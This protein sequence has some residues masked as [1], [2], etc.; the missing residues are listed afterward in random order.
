M[1]NFSRLRY[2]VIFITFIANILVFC[3]SAY[4][5]YQSRNQYEDRARTQTQTIARIL[6]QEISV[7]VERIDF[8]LRSV[9]DDIDRQ[10][11]DKGI[12]GPATE[13]LLNRYKQRMPEVEGLRLTNKN[14]DI[15]LGTE[16]DYN[17]KV[18]VA[19]REYFIHHVGNNDDKMHISQPVIGRV[20][21]HYII[22]FSRHYN[23]PD[24]S[25]AGVVYA[26][27]PVD[28]FAALLSRFDV[29]RHGTIVLRDQHLA[30]I[31]RIPDISD[32]PVG[33]V[34]NNTVSG[35]FQQI[36][37]TGAKFSTYYTRLAADGQKRM[38]SFRR[39]DQAE[40]TVIVG[41]SQDDYLADWFKE[42]YETLAWNLALLLATLLSARVLLKTLAAL[43]ESEG[44]F[45]RFFEK[46]SSVML[47]VEPSTG[48]I[49]GA[50][51]V[52]AVFYGY[53]PERLV[54]MTTNEINV[55]PPEDIAQER[56]RALL[57]ERN[58]FSFR[59]RLASNDIRDVEVYA[60][61]IEFDH[62]PLLFSIVHD[63][64][65]RKLAE[66]ARQKSEAHLRSIFDAT[67]DALLISDASGMI[68]M[69]NQRAER[70]LGYLVDDLLGLPV[71][72]LVPKNVRDRHPEL[73][74][75]Y[76]AAPSDLLMGHR[77]EIKVVRK[78]G[79][80]CDV[81]V[82]LGHIEIGQDS[83]VAS[84][85]RDITDRRKAEAE[86][87]IAATAFESQESI[88]VTD[89]QG[90][91]LRVNRAFTENT[92]YTSEEIIGLTPSL[93]KSGRHD[94]VFY[95]EMWQDLT[96]HGVWQGE[97]WDK[98][99]N[100]E[101]YPK[102]LTISAVRDENGVTT[103]YVG[104]H[105]DISERKRAE[106]KII[107][108]AFYDQLT[109][110]PNRTLLL[111]RLS[112][113]MKSRL[114]ICGAL[115]F[116]DLDNFKTLNDTLGHHKGD[117]L[118]CQVAQRL[119]KCVRA[120]DTVA[121]LGGDEF[122]VLLED[123][124]TNEAEASL[125]A[126]VIG[127][128]IK[129]ALNE[130]YLL[131]E[132][133]YHCTPSIGVT[134]FAGDN[135]SVTDL[136]KQADLAMYKSKDAGRNAIHFF[137]PALES[138]VV[139]RASLEA[140]LRDALDHGQFIL[141]YQPQIEGKDHLAGAEALVRWQHPQRGLVPPSDFIPI[142]EETGLIL[143]LGNWVLE[144][145][146]GQL[147][148]WANQPTMADLTIAVNVSAGQFKH[149]NFVEHVLSI[150]KK[151]NANPRRLKLELT[152]SLLVVNLQD[153]IEKMF[154]LKAKGV[155]F[156]LDDFGTGYSSLSYL[157]RL[158][159]DQLKIDQSF[160]R[161]LL[162]DPND[163]AIARTIVA[164]AQSLGLAVIAE[165][166]ETEHQRDFLASSGCH[167]YQGYLFSRPLPL[168]AFEKFSLPPKMK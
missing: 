7:S 129:D 91:I 52:A 87:R 123:L 55:L 9:V 109:G 146:C 46:N 113:A 122:L 50:N 79:S 28:H 145:A 168:E 19:D 158:P 124:S 140:D 43:H 132:T 54:G 56:Q 152:E 14:G 66:L 44:R 23:S 139:K 99:K 69:A 162:V 64:T 27:V 3:L 89:A 86:L 111:D 71:D 148:K 138:V 133:L 94:P 25:F 62:K 157:K 68:I 78:D 149:P 167:A 126:E 2:L 114:R 33:K 147:A 6:D 77:R 151:T 136:L 135:A 141:H 51:Q 30:L 31:T 100:G 49:V 57:E 105:L 75:R 4:W 137:D 153:I 60:T 41:L 35:E 18:N 160:V 156:S 29:G 150:L 144:T 39:L 5:L 65:E 72:T 63:V 163:A 8:A 101:V 48:E 161:D 115:L 154:S 10:L 103:N 26:S 85:L 97:I 117:L 102:W 127:E 166:V 67:P 159:L 143:P 95:Q 83:Y 17:N 110:L 32:Q 42:F 131:E 93:F 36:W 98:R 20:I 12:D 37:R 16:I 125:K 76:I 73:R 165:G 82:T 81:E 112:Q 116:I 107:D 34:G 104:T 88:I 118:L 80:Q 53:P 119:T 96:R 155:G 90:V 1:I 130:K 11:A 47:L 120:G 45:R 13:D 38:L 134:L 58:Y 15:I 92:G 59:H 106:E 61:P 84:A 142:A 40:M 21:K 22:I 70:L 74:S 128:K 121:R 164:L 108:L 24:G